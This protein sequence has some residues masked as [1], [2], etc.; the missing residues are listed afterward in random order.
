M[1]V[2]P[3]FITPRNLL[4]K[5]LLPISVTFCSAGL[6]VLAPKGGKIPP[7]YT[8]I[9]SNRKLRLPPG[10]SGPIT[11][12]DQQ[13]KQEVTVLDGWLTLRTM[14]GST[15]VAW[16]IPWGFPWA[17]YALIESERLRP[18]SDRTMSG[19]S[20]SG[21]NA[22]SPHQSKYFITRTASIMSISSLFC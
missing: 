22:R 10:H 3:L 20:P 5:C 14:A 17:C 12:R 4:A 8:V 18:G 1:G 16:A 6:E 9:P 21:M 13:A 15:S 11:L 2:A 19:P 7:G